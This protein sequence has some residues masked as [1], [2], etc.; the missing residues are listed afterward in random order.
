MWRPS[1][2][3][4]VL[5]AGADHNS[6][7]AH[8]DPDR[9]RAWR[10]DPFYK[11]LKEWSIAAMPQDGQV[12]VRIGRKTI[13][14]LPNKD[15]DLGIV[16]DDEVICTKQTLTDGGIVCNAFK[17]KRD[18]PRARFQSVVPKIAGAPEFQAQLRDLWSAC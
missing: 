3:K 4:I 9:P 16:A 10:R 12:R 8:V 17:V 11:T 18:D 7:V 1:N 6:I 13:V 14:I 2:S 15:V 5:T